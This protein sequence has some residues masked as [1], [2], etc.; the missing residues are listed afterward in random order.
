MPGAIVASPDQSAPAARCASRR[1]EAWGAALLVGGGVHVLVD[2]AERRIPELARALDPPVCRFDAI[3]QVE[4][5]IE[6]LFV[7]L[8]GREQKA[9]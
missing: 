7:A 1:H 8:L 4:P 6:D 9:A 2:D 3:A 5:T